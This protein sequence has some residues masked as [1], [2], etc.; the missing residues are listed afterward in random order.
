MNRDLQKMVILTGATFR[1]V[2]ERRRRVDILFD[3]FSEVS[4]KSVKRL[5]IMS[6]FDGDVKYKNIFPSYTVKSWK[7]F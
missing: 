6:S 3:V 2:A 5:K 7:S 1:M 4:I